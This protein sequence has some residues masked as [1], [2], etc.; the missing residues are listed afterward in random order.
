MLKLR[1]FPRQNP[2]QQRWERGWEAGSRADF[3]GTSRGYLR[4]AVR[5]S[6]VGGPSSRR[7]PSQTRATGLPLPTGVLVRDPSFT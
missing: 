4:R 7:S 5:A 1:R 2:E 6:A 3:E